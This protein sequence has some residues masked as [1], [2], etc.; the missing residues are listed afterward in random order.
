M[1]MCMYMCMCMHLHVK[2]KIERKGG[3]EGGGERKSREKRLHC[4]FGS[5]MHAWKPWKY[6]S[7]IIMKI[8][9]WIPIGMTLQLVINMQWTLWPRVYLPAVNLCKPGG[10]SPSPL[11]ISTSKIAYCWWLPSA[12]SL[13]PHL[14]LPHWPKGLFFI[15]CLKNLSLPVESYLFGNCLY[16]FKFS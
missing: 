14:L 2:R 8:I 5:Y 12:K 10:F 4:L 13:K 15:L 7:I 16:Y 3:R 1:Y 6:F 9:P 11:T